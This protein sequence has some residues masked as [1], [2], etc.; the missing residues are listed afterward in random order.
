MTEAGKVELIESELTAFSAS[1]KYRLTAMSMG[2]CR[3]QEPLNYRG[4]SLV[5]LFYDK[6]LL[7]FHPKLTSFHSPWSFSL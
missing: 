2:R 3:P 1:G 6:P 7:T 4:V 5:G